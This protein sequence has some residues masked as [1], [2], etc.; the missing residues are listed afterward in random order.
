L[1]GVVVC[2]EDDGLGMVIGVNDVAAGATRDDS[3]PA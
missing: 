2:T 1:K 3:G